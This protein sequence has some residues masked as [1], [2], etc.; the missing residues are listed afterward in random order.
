MT[1]ALRRALPF[2]ACTAILLSAAPLR[3]PLLAQDSRPAPAYGSTLTYGTGL[4]NTP[5][6]WVSPNN[7]D[8]FASVSARIIGIGSVTPKPQGSLWDLTENLEAHIGGRFAAGIS[9]YNTKN[10]QVGGFASL[11][12]FREVESGSPRYLPSLAVGVRGLGWSA[13][14]DRYVT[15]DRRVAD[16][17]LV[18]NPGAKAPK[19]NGNPSLYG[20]LTRE[21]QFSKADASL[22]VGY[23]SGLFKNN[24]G[25]D[26]IY[27]KH[28]TVAS[29][30]FFGGR[31]VIPAGKNA[32]VS[33]IGENDGWD[34]NAGAQ[35]TWGHVSAGLYFLELEESNKVP[36]GRP[37]AN[38][39]RTALMLSY[40]ASLPDIIRGGTDRSQAAEAQIE[41]RRLAQEIEQRK[42]R[43]TEMTEALVKAQSGADKATAAQR[44]A[45]QKQLNEEREAMKRAAD[46]LEAL[47][48]G[49]PVPQGDIR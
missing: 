6:A 30:L 37:I 32:V 15:G 36:Y 42:A 2:V 7:G 17:L 8:L 12:V 31:V 27:N 29:G 19:I 26:T 9:L 11:L 44:A 49:K 16:A 3:A 22:S 48:K 24:G 13:Y 43:A 38:F 1:L 20:V 46:R 18:T 28:G 40:N 47:Q 35:V 14:Q 39:T 41:A 25:L 4:I 23:G 5:T 34:F 45:L 21:F 10:Q 33:L